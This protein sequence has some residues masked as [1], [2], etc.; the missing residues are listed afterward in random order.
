MNFS[1]FVV[2]AFLTFALYVTLLYL[3]SDFSGVLEKSEP[4]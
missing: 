4:T 3:V 2:S 1:L